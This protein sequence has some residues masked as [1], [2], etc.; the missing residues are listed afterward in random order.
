MLFCVMKFFFSNHNNKLENVLDCHT[1][2][3]TLVSRVLAEIDEMLFT[4]A[5]VD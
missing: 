4:V 3:P 5:V 1:S 2:D